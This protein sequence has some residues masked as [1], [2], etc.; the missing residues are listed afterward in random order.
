V[1]AR[2]ESLAHPAGTRRHSHPW[3]QLSY[4]IQGVLEVHTADGRFVA[5]PERAIWLPQDVEHEVF[6]SADAEI[7]SLYLDVSIT[8]WAPLRCRVIEIE[9]LTR[10]LIR[11]FSELPIEYEQDGPAGRLVD[12]LL[13]QLESAEEL[14]F[15]LPWPMS[16]MLEEICRELQKNPESSRTL[17]S[18]S[19]ELGLAEKT[20][21]RQFRLQTGLTYRG[22]RQ[23][24]RLFSALLP[25][26]RGERVT[27]VALACGYESTSAFIAAFR[28]HFGQTPGELF[29]R[30]AG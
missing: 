22:W 27:D 17:R 25:L 3:V 4:A 6:S 9:P 1:Y 5:L 15:S 24:L 8:P 23:R 20:L 30:D 13:D 29:R 26:E 14:A 18:W 10:E 11:R 21:S 19:E 2:S 28:H 12:V 7:R 16:P